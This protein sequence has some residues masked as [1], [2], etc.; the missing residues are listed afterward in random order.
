MKYN[1][2]CCLLKRHILCFIASRRRI[3][4]RNNRVSPFDSVSVRNGKQDSYG[5]LCL[6]YGIQ[7]ISKQMCMA[8]SNLSHIAIYEENHT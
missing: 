8:G 1:N 4:R 6:T 2:L 3:F 7:S 5:Q